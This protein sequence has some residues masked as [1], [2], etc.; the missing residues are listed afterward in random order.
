MTIDKVVHF[1][2]ALKPWMNNEWLFSG[3]AKTI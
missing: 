2:K 3:Q 1:I